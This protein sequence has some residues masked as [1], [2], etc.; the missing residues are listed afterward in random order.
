MASDN[1]RNIVVS[2]SLESSSVGVH[3]VS[4]E[5]KMVGGEEAEVHLC[6]LVEGKWFIRLVIKWPLTYFP[7]A[8]DVKSS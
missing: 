5:T 6:D 4:V 1:G 8:N 3:G 7:L 2:L